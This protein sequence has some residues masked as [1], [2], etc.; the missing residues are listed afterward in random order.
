MTEQNVPKTLDEAY[1]LAAEAKPY[2]DAFGEELAKKFG[3]EFVSAPLKGR[4]RAEEKLAA[5][6]HG[7]LSRLQDIARCR[8]VCDS[9]EQIDAIKKAVKEHAVPL[10]EV[11]RF[12]K[13]NERG[14]RDLKYVF[15][16]KNGFA[17]EMQIQLRDF[18]RAD[19]KTHPHYEKIRSIT[20]A[21]KDRPLTETEQKEINIH[22]KI[23]Q[24][25]FR[26]AALAYNERTTG[27]KLKIQPEQKSPV[28]MALKAKTAGAG[29]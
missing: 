19:E 1:K 24:K 12:D 18:A 17:V 16:E 2:L 29:R 21:A 28:L 25:I 13:P 4:Q 14:Y 6:Y 15:P 8:V 26:D 9:L 23:C 7:D 5:K 10:R 3:C 22:E 20:A 27:R 11:D